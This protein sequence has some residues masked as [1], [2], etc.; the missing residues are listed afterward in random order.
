MAEKE[1]ALV[2]QDNRRRRNNICLLGLPENL[3]SDQHEVFLERWLPRVLHLPLS[4]TLEVKRTHRVPTK[5]ASNKGKCPTVHYTDVEAILKKA[6]EL[7]G[8]KF[9]DNTTCIG[10]DFAKSAS[11]VRDS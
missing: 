6:K 3:E 1:K 10:P 7:K 11:M 5:R 9:E 2:D 4:G 8:I